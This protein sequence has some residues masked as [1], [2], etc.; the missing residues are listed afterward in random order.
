MNTLHTLCA[1]LVFV[2]S[3]GAVLAQDQH[4]HDHGTKPAEDSQKHDPSA[5]PP[6]EEAHKHDAHPSEHG[7]SMT[8]NLGGYPM[9]RDASGTSWQPDSTEHAMGHAM[10]GD[11]MLMGHVLL[12]GVYDWQD[13]DAEPRSVH[14]QER[15]SVA[16][17]CR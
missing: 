9:T 17:G 15:L 8:G 13:G 7:M 14:G 5:H 11:W 16:L 10:S 4:Q 3:G 2:A 1:T 6:A 12:N